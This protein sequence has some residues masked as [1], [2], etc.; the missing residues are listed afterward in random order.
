MN[1]GFFAVKMCDGK[2][3]SDTKG[4]SLKKTEN[5]NLKFLKIC[6]EEKL[7]VLE[8]ENFEG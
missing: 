8:I 3:C 7:K 2:N 5:S 1:R 4:D 6:L